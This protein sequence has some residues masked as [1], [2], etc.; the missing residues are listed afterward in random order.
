[1]VVV[2]SEKRLIASVQAVAVGLRGRK[3]GVGREG[4]E[5]KPALLPSDRVP[6]VV[7]ALVENVIGKEVPEG[8]TF[9]WALPEAGYT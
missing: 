4:D 1:M 5:G 9:P 8:C 3:G 6:T 7:D 2:V